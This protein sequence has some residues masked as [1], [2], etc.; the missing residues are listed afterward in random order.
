MWP[1]YC[2]ALFS[3]YVITMR[4]KRMFRECKNKELIVSVL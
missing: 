1:V 3:R 4:E 2:M